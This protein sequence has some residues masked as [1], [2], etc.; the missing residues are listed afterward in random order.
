MNKKLI[1][2]TFGWGPGDIWHHN[3]LESP[4]P[5]RMILE[6]S[7]DGLCTLSFALSQFHGHGSWPVC[8]VTHTSILHSP[9]YSVGPSSAV[10]I[11]LGPAPPFSPMRALEVKWWRAL[12]LVFE[13]ALSKSRILELNLK[14]ESQQWHDL[15]A[16]GGVV[17]ISSAIVVLGPTERVPGFE[18]VKVFAKL[19]H[20]TEVL[21][22][23]SEVV[24]L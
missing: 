9:T 23:N 13:V 12:S 17:K 11:E 16:V 3:T 8:E 2:T 14:Q 7:W 21:C 19:E 1:E 24:G 22:G 15:W 6:V 10:G 5:H 4:W 20:G 18:E